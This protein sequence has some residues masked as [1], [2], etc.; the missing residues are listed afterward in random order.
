MKNLIILMTFSFLLLTA[1]S[2]EGDN[3]QNEET[4]ANSVYVLKQSNE[5]TSFEV[6]SVED[7]SAGP[8]TSPN[9]NSLHASGEFHGFGPGGEISFNA[10]ENNGGAHGGGKFRVTFG[11]FGT[12]HVRLQTVSLIS[13]G[14]D[15]VIFGGVITEVFENTVSFPPPPP[16]GPPPPPCDPYELGT[17]V[18]FSV[19]DNG[20]GNNAPMDQ[21]HTF[22]ANSCFESASD[23]AGLPWFFGIFTNVGSPSDKIK[24]ND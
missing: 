8:V 13:S 7:F 19:K 10:T 17:Y 12:A 24:V 1:C 3:D 16:G 14:E 6:V 2:K 4:S 22:L 11:P 5:I 18:Y 15:E 9:G 23:G 21:Y 20:Q